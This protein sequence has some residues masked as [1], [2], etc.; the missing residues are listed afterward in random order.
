MKKKLL[1]LVAA[2][3]FG[4]SLYSTSAMA[5]NIKV[6]KGDTLSKYSKQ[7]HISV[8]SIKSANKLKNDR[9]IVGQNINIPVKGKSAVKASATPTSY[10]YTVKKGDTLSAIAKKYHTTLKQLKSLNGLKSD[11]IKQGQKLKVSG[12]MTTQS[13][14]TNETTRTDVQELNA[15]KLIRDAK[16]VIGTPYK[17]GGTTPSGFDCSGFIYYVINK[18]KPIS[19]QT[20]AGYWSM[21]KPVSTLSVGDFVYYETYKSGPSHM[22]IYVGDGKF[23]HAGSSDGIE[24]SEMNNSYWKPKYLGARRL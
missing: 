19:R 24:I 17:W 7:Y 16:A 5:M 18:Q 15:D 21:M 22:G 6:K 9:I 1:T 3:V 2:T 8:A 4:T 23:I 12:K 11:F 14:N 13:I 20:V 10:I